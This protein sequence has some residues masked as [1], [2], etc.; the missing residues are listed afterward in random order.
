VLPIFFSPTASPTHPKWGGVAIDGSSVLRDSCYHLDN[1]DGESEE[2]PVKTTSAPVPILNDSTPSLSYLHAALLQPRSPHPAANLTSDGDSCA[3]SPP[4]TP[5]DLYGLRHLTPSDGLWRTRLP[6]NSNLAT[7]FSAISRHAKIGLTDN[8][9]ARKGNKLKKMCFRC[10]STDH[11]VSQ[12]R[13]PIKCASCF[14]SGHR[15]THCKSFKVTPSST[16][17]PIV[18]A[19]SSASRAPS[20]PR[21]PPSSPH[22]EG[23][24]VLGVPWPRRMFATGTSWTPE[25]LPMSTSVTPHMRLTC[26]YTRTWSRRAAPLRSSWRRRQ[27]ALAS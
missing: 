15:S 26:S 23:A 8:F 4:P 21:A 12:C 7:T 14:R 2:S 22:D 10:L 9:Q 11:L 16:A 17:K 6:S 3:Y 1:I 19:A 18:M 5:G 24:P 25:L 27:G 20:L 13:D